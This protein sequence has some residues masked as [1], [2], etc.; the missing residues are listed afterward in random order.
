MARWN[1]RYDRA[2]NQIDTPEDRILMWVSLIV[3]LAVAISAVVYFNY[4]MNRTASGSNEELPAILRS[5]LPGPQQQ[6]R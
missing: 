2:G 3:A 6:P 4:G 5:D 1:V